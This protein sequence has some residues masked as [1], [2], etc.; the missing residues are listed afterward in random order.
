MAEAPKG[1]QS[2]A[3][4][5]CIDPI[6]ASMEQAVVEVARQPAQVPHTSCEAGTAL[7]RPKPAPPY[8][9][10]TA[11]DSDPA[12]SLTSMAHHAKPVIPSGRQGAGHRYLRG[13]STGRCCWR[14]ALAA[15]GSGDL[16]RPSSEQGSRPG[17]ESPWRQKRR[18]QS[19]KGGLIAQGW[20]GCHAWGR[21]WPWPAVLKGCMC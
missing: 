15:A 19:E 9:A 13:I 12:G 5:A 11:P 7:Q 14:W 2:T 10:V 18:V 4:Q 8:S 6:C 17:L 3:V 21:L 20:L 1:R 16:R